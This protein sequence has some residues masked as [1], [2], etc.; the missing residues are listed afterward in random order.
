MV[1]FRFPSF[2]DVLTFLS[3]LDRK[4]SFLTV[5]RGAKVRN[6]VKKKIPHM[7]KTVKFVRLVWQCDLGRDSHF[8]LDFFRFQ[9]CFPCSDPSFAPESH[10]L[11]VFP[12]SIRRVRVEKKIPKLPKTRDIGLTASDK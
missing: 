8:Q 11:T 2:P 9:V 10:F 6:G 1:F 5:F 12:C 7:F 4:S 3:G